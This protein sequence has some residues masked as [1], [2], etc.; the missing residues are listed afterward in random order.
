MNI[1]KDEDLN[2]QEDILSRLFKAAD[3]CV[4][5]EGLDPE[6]CEVSLTVVSPEEIKSINAQFRGI[7]AVTDVLSFPQFDD[8]ND[9]EGMDEICLG[10]VVICSDV[11]E[12]QAREY[13]HSYEREFVY[14]FVHSMLHLLGYDHM[15]EEEKAEMRKREEEVMKEVDL[16][17]E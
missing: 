11:A 14:L 17:R 3:I 7:D 4:S 16:V 6:L 8:L 10:D 5:G 15:E 2:I 1:I 13:G 9:T 12:N